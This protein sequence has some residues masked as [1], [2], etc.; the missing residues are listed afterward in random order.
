MTGEPLPWVSLALAFWPLWV[1]Y[2][3]AVAVAVAEWAAKR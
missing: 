3:V 1:V 2:I